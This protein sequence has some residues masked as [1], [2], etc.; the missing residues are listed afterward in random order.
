MRPDWRCE[1]RIKR[2]PCGAGHIFER[3]PGTVKRI[4]EGG[5]LK[6]GS[7][8]RGAV[9]QQNPIGDCATRVTTRRSEGQVVQLQR[10]QILAIAKDEVM[11]VD[12]A[13]VGFG[14]RF[15]RLGGVK[16]GAQGCADDIS[17]RH[18]LS[19]L[20]RKVSDHALGHHRAR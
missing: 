17:F 5:P 9:K 7:R 12:K 16:L 19:F 2:A 11:E 18:E 1:V 20:N 14:L 3:L 13:V 6:V 15:S 4:G 10:R 8:S